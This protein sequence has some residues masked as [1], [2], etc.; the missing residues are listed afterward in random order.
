MS[1]GSR[2]PQPSRR[3]PTVTTAPLQPGRR[4][5]LSSRNGIASHRHQRERERRES[6]YLR[7]QVERTATRQVTAQVRCTVRSQTGV[8]GVPIT[9]TCLTIAHN[10]TQTPM[11]D[12]HMSRLERGEWSSPSSLLTPSLEREVTVTEKEQSRKAPASTPGM[13][14]GVETENNRTGSQER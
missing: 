6:F 13:A 10:D 14:R 9:A 7:W 8:L 11:R 5:P 12:S 4:Q 3:H 2:P 1:L